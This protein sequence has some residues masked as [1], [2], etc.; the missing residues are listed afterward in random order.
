MIQV[1]TERRQTTIVTTQ[2]STNTAIAVSQETDTTE[3][4]QFHANPTYVTIAIP[5]LDRLTH[6]TIVQET[7]PTPIINRRRHH[8]NRIVI[9]LDPHP[10]INTTLDLL[11]VVV[12]ITIAI[13]LRLKIVNHT[14]ETTTTAI[15]VT[16]PCSLILPPRR[17]FSPKLLMSVTNAPSFKFK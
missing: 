17:Q 14:P 9:N 10:F 11:T 1:E 3:I 2:T 4:A 5:V 6:T 13:E 12:R 15:A 16:S 7:T 8:T